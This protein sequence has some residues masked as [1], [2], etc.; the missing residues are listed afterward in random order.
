MRTALATALL[1]ILT[2]A[3]SAQEDGAAAVAAAGDKARQGDY[4]GALEILEPLAAAPDAGAEVLSLAGSLYLELGRPGQALAA[5]ERLAGAGIEDAVVLFN[6]GRA[7]LAMGRREEAVRY[8]ESS[9]RR[10]PLSVAAITLAELRAEDGQHAGVVELLRPLV[11]GTPAEAL[12]ERDVNLAAAVSFRC[13]RSLLELGEDEAAAAALE[14]VTGLKPENETA[15]RMLGETLID[16]GRLDAAYSAMA[17]V[18]ELAE[19]RR[20][21]EIETLGDAA[22]P[23]SSVEDLVARAGE[24]QEAGR[25][26]EALEVLRRAMALA[27][28]DPRPRLM[29][30]RLLISLHREAEAL[31][32][33]E[34]LVRIVPDH[35]EGYYLR[36]MARLAAQ[37]LGAAEKD[38]RR[39]LDL[40]PDH[41]AGLNGLAIVLMARNQNA[42][43]EKVLLRALRRWPDDELAARNL[44]KVRRAA[45][46]A[47]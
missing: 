37:D 44:A 35:P 21:Q 15:W 41:L 19:A 45:N 3:A 11:E 39:V 1:L 40:D 17:R 29:E 4:E 16:L 6:A 46:D 2:V 26:D 28:N 33:A 32:R 23:G 43:A 5:L 47:N 9:A 22:A 31:P 14:R 7:A 34:M 38:L 42:E 25:G 30:I 13:A 27:P 18:Q 20:A 10:A 8:L 12:A 24:L 36:G